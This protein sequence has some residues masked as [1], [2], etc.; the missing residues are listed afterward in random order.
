MILSFF[1]F[2]GNSQNPSSLSVCAS[3]CVCVTDLCARGLLS[4]TRQL[5][6]HKIQ[7]SWEIRVGRPHRKDIDL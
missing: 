2:L 3:V 6:G 1:L 4:L 5:L 7:D